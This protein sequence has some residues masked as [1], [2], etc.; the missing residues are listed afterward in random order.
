MNQRVRYIKSEDGGW[1]SMKAVRSADGTDY[2]AIINPDGLSGKIITA[3]KSNFS[4]EVFA[5][6]PHKVKI[7]LKTALQLLKCTFFGEKR[8]PRKQGEENGN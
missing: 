8:K 6:S 4:V 3:K 1:K 2:L 5:T 7:K